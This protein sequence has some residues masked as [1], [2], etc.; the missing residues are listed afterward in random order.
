MGNGKGTYRLW[1][2]KMRVEL[3][4]QFACCSCAT[5]TPNTRLRKESVSPLRTV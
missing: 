2:V 5:L 3:P 4:R 1:P